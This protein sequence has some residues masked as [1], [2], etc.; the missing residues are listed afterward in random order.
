MSAIASAD[1]G[2]CDA[3]FTTAVFPQA[4]AGA[5]FHEAITPGKFHGVIRAHTPT[6]SRRVTSIPGGATGIVSPM[7]LVAAP[8]QY[9]NTLATSSISP[10]AA[11]IGLPPLRASSCASSSFR[12]RIANDARRRIRPRSRA[13]MRGHAPSSKAFAATSTARAASSGPPSATSQPGS[14]VAGSI[15][16]WVL[17]SSAGTRSPPSTSSSVMRSPSRVATTR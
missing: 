16:A 17:P 9:S 12:S 1:S 7:I 15:K 11:E 2:V 5:I 6:G 14:A 4:S 13:L 8:P 3:G 10:R